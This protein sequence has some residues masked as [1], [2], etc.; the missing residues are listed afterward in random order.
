MRAPKL[1]ILLNNLDVAEWFATWQNKRE[2]VATY[3]F[4]IVSA[5]PISRVSQSKNCSSQLFKPVPA[6]EGVDSPFLL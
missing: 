5:V 2:G 6:Q 3:I 4:A 1:L